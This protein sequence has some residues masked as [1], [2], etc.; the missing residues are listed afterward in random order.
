M[1]A[2]ELVP[3]WLLDV[4]DSAVVWA[5]GAHAD[6]PA[7]PDP[8]SAPPSPRDPLDISLFL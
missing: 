2:H 6:A 8:E 4:W 1:R 7:G 5:S 3:G